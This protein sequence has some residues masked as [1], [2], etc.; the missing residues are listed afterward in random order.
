MIAAWFAV[1]LPDGVL[2]PSWWLGGWVV[3]AGLLGLSSWRVQAEDIPRLA[4]V[5]AACFVAS[6]IHIPLGT[7]SVHLL[8][9]CLAVLLAGPRAPLAIFP[10]LLLQALLLNHGGLLTL[11]VNTAIYTLPALVVWLLAYP[12][13]RRF[14]VLVSVRWAWLTGLVL[15]G[16]TTLVTVAL[17][18]VVLYLGGIEKWSALVLLVFAAHVPV[19][20][21]EACMTASLLTYLCRV[22]PDLLALPCPRTANGK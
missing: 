6:S 1:H 8:M 4:L 3:T 15:G 10:A 12:V 5:S 16:L 22:K 7:T 18:A 13:V 19:V 20:F 11:G 21:V 9:N 17:N 14:P 2:T